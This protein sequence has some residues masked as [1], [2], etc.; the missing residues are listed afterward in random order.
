MDKVEKFILKFAKDTRNP[1]DA[2]KYVR[3]EDTGYPYA[4]E[5]PTRAKFWTD[6]ASALKY[7]K[8]FNTEIEQKVYVLTATVDVIKQNLWCNGT[9]FGGIADRRC[10]SQNFQHRGHSITIPRD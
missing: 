3:L 4:V 6:E 2:G 9:E 8:Q 10:P 1:P 7:A 5:D